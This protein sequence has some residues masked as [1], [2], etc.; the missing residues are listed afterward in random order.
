MEKFNEIELDIAK[1]ILN[2]GLSKSADSL[3]FFT[4]DKVLIN[5]FDIYSSEVDNIKTLSSNFDKEDTY[6]LSTELK[7]ELT[8]ECFL[9]FNKSEVEELLKAMLPASILENQAQKEEMGNAI[10]LEL[11]NIVSAAV[12]TQFSNILQCSS[13]GNVPRLDVIEPKGLETF[14][15]SRIIDEDHLVCFKA[16][17]ITENVKLQPEFIWGL[18]ER[19]VEGVKSIASDGGEVLSAYRIKQK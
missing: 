8:G 12:I 9:I 6:V 13:Y 19:F 10:L 3:S 7:G 5:T 15:K 11:D 16:E 17:F 4:K 2:I 18:N 1:E 14:L